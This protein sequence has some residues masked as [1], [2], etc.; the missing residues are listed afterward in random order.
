MDKDHLDKLI[1]IIK[2]RDEEAFALMKY[3]REDDIRIK[4]RFKY[5]IFFIIY[6]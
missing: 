6:N 4:V 1:D 5:K 3:T 2:T